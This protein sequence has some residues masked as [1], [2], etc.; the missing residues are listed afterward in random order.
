MREGVE[1]EHD[2]RQEGNPG[3]DGS[4][5]GKTESAYDGLG[6]IDMIPGARV[7]DEGDYG[8]RES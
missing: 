4:C 6:S 3:K 2:G 7:H 5:D 8:V 1:G